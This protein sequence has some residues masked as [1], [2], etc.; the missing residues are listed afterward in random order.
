MV[1][2][3]AL[4]DNALSLVMT[5]QQVFERRMRK[6]NQTAPKKD[7]EFFDPQELDAESRIR[8]YQSAAER[9]HSRQARAELLRH[10][11]EAFSWERHTYY[12]TYTSGSGILAENRHVNKTWYPAQDTMPHIMIKLAGADTKSLREIGAAVADTDATQ[13]GKLENYQAQERD[14]KRNLNLFFTLK[15][16]PE[17][18][19]GMVSQWM[20]ANHYGP[21]N[22]IYN[23][24]SDGGSSALDIIKEW[25][26]Q[27][28]HELAQEAKTVIERQM[29]LEKLSLQ[30]SGAGRDFTLDATDE[31]GRRTYLMGKDSMNVLSLL[32]AI[33]PDGNASQKLNISGQP[34]SAPEHPIPHVAAGSQLVE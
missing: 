32:A 5:E 34:V 25:P 14:D 21:L 24:K 31:E 8:G 20:N 27:L 17:V 10:M 16:H 33:D 4:V 29:Q 22:S 1:N 15:N 30:K 26:P 9:A 13:Y 12:G 2:P 18:Q 19:L 11:I 7:S 28:R 6:L 23:V 3:T